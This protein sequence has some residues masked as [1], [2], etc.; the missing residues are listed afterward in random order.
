MQL[1]DKPHVS[2]IVGNSSLSKK[3]LDEIWYDLV[4][5]ASRTLFN[6]LVILIEIWIGYTPSCT[7]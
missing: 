7:S 5:H 6:V 2:D 1:V 3:M 4:E